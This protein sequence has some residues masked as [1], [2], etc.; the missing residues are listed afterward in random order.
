MGKNIFIHAFAFVHQQHANDLSR[1]KYAAM[2][3]NQQP[4]APPA[5]MYRVST[6]IT[7]FFTASNHDDPENATQKIST[8]IDDQR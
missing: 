6:I 2:N 5:I 1:E 4:R 7:P 8:S 3:N